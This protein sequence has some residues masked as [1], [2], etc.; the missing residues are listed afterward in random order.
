M[1]IDLAAILFFTCGIL[2]GILSGIIIGRAKGEAD[3]IRKVKQL[4]IRGKLDF[5]LEEML[6][7]KVPTPKH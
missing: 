3:V 4:V 7:S 5:D 2:T 1:H 6:R